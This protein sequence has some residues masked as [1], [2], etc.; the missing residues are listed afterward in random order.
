MSWLIWIIYN[1]VLIYIWLSCPYHDMVLTGY[2]CNPH[3]I[4]QIWL[5]PKNWASRRFILCVF[6]SILIKLWYVILI[7]ILWH[8][9]Q[10]CAII[11]YN[12]HDYYYGKIDAC[13]WAVHVDVMLWYWKGLALL[14]NI[15]QTSTKH[16]VPAQLCMQQAVSLC[17]LTR[18]IVIFV[19]D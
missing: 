6:L 2:P 7:N 8:K 10:L 4:C 11:L 9:Q 17:F 16:L 18:K 5:D 3:V 13:F 1:K 14:G 12:C 15:D 19:Y